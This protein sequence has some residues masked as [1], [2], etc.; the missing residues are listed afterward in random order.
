VVFAT[1]GITLISRSSA[2]KS[3]ASK[4]LSPA[5]MTF[6]GRL[7]RGSTRC[8]APG[9]RG[10]KHGSRGH[11]RSG[12]CA[13]P[14]AH[15]LRSKACPPCLATCDKAGHQGRWL[16]RGYRCCASAAAPRP[17]YGS[18]ADSGALWRC[19]RP[20]ID[21]QHDSLAWRRRRRTFVPAKCSARQASGP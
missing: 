14:S 20:S 11:R 5:S 13:S 6:C 21:Q 16:Q 17:H 10:P 2:T 7:A 3:C 12:Q 18:A 1:C 19:D 4:P 15:G 9:R 8:G